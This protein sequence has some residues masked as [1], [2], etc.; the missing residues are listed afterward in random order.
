[1]VHR[2]WLDFVG[3]VSVKHH[4]TRFCKQP[5]GT[6]MLQIGSKSVDFVGQVSV[7]HRRREAICRVRAD[8]GNTGLKIRTPRRGGLNRRE[9]WHLWRRARRV[10]LFVRSLTLF[11]TY[12]KK[13]DSRLPLNLI[14]R[15]W[16]SEGCRKWR[17]EGLLWLLEVG[18]ETSY[19]DELT[20]TRRYF[21]SHRETWHLC[22]GRSWD[23]LFGRSLT[24]FRTDL[25]K[26]EQN[27]TFELGSSLIWFWGVL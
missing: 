21:V 9:T 10:E 5:C 7:K 17:L 15:C 13:W 3:Q 6:G 1:M 26:L 11:R 16:D 27:V 2:P 19:P 24:C 4:S 14:L 22:R 25:K 20:S 23:V 12:L 8:G 18:V